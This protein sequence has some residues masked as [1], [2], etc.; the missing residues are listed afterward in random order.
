[1]VERKIQPLRLNIAG[2]VG[3][4]CNLKWS[5]LSSPLVST[6]QWWC[7]HL[8]PAAQPCTPHHCCCVSSPTSSHTQTVFQEWS[9]ELWDVQEL[10]PSCAEREAAPWQGRV[11]HKWRHA[12]C[13]LKLRAHHH[14][15]HVCANWRPNVT[16]SVHHKLVW[17]TP[18]YVAYSFTCCKFAIGIKILKCQNCAWSLNLLW[19]KEQTGES[20]IV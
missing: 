15:L 13:K 7:T 2:W 18:I 6:Y 8:L 9:S 16:L 17:V 20:F 4:E 11:T 12:M 10:A 5:S 1:M 19:F 3:G 14:L